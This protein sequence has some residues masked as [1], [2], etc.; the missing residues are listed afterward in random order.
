MKELKKIVQSKLFC[1]LIQ[2]LILYVSVNLVRYSIYIP[3]SS[4]TTFERHLIINF[5]SDYVIF[6]TLQEMGFMFLLWFYVS[7]VP[8]I[9]FL[10]Y[11]KSYVVNLTTFF[12]INF[13]F[14]AFLFKYAKLKFDSVFSVLFPRTIVLALFVLLSTFVLSLILEALVDT[15]IKPDYNNLELLYQNSRSTCPNC[16]ETFESIPI[17]CYNC[18][19]MIRNDFIEDK[20]K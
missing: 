6:N 13:F 4:D 15:F 9:I 12:V 5:L 2:C 7:L 3:I 1:F 8:I 11:R 17:Y 18:N 10:D 19:A 16:G 14:Y 20:E